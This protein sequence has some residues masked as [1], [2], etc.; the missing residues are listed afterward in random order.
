MFLLL[1][2][3]Y[4]NPQVTGLLNK[5]LDGVPVF[6]RR[7]FQADTSSCLLAETALMAGIN[8]VEWDKKKKTG[9]SV[10]SVNVE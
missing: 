1:L 7:C 3:M 4:V 10:I 8:L 9:S 2:K 5:S 6:P